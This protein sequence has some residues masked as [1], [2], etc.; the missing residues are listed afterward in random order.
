MIVEYYFLCY[1][2]SPLGLLEAELCK[3]G[4]KKVW[5]IEFQMPCP[6]RIR[7]YVN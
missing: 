1:S 3:R 6:R 4:I 7:P 5:G 2:T